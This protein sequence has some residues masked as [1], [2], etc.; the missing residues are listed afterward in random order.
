[1]G[2]ALS[3]GDVFCRFGVIESHAVLHCAERR[4]RLTFTADTARRPA[5]STQGG[6][7]I[8]RQPNCLSR[9]E[10]VRGG[11]SRR[12]AAVTAAAPVAKGF[13]FGETFCHR[14]R[15]FPLSG[16]GGR[17]EP[18]AQS[19][20]P[21]GKADESS[22]QNKPTPDRKF[23]SALT[24]PYLLTQSTHSVRKIGQF[25]TLYCLYI[26]LFSCY[27]MGWYP[28]IFT[29]YFKEAISYGKKV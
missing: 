5:F 14:R 27:N 18:S 11:K 21:N 24:S 26:S 9:G 20:F 16:C 10:R 8:S 12:E 3:V 2:A 28:I 4:F 7:A 23:P 22:S 17:R 25:F 15:N 19:V 6:I 13:P 1:M 29:I